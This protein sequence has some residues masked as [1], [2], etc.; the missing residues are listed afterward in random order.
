[1]ATVMDELR[2]ILNGDTTMM[3]LL[4]GGV[5]DAPI[6]TQT[7]VVWKTNPIT[8]V[9]VIRPVGVL[10]EPQEVDSPFGLNPRRRL[11]TDL[12]PELYLYAE[13]SD[14]AD[15]FDAADDRAME[16]LHRQRIDLSDIEATGFRARPLEADELPGHVWHIFRRY[17]VQ[18]VRHLQEA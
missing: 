2:A 1:M 7:P 3:G 10:L 17:R 11:D 8:G 13:F 16:L 4:P 12:W 9:K 14:M 5:L 6:T 15:V 18:T